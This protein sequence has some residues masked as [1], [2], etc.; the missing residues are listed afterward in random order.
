MI[1]YIISGQMEIK[2]KD[3]ENLKK[4]LELELNRR[5]YARSDLEIKIDKKSG[6]L[7]IVVYAKDITAYKATTNNYIDILELIKK[8]YE[9]EL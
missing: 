7:T 3:V 5:S 2:S 6:V 1:D 8:T 9:V 4:I